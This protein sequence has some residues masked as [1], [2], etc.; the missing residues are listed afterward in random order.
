MVSFLANANSTVQRASEDHLR[1]R[2]MSVYSMLFL[3]MTPLGSFII[4]SISEKT[5]T[6]MALMASSGLCLLASVLFITR[7]KKLI[8]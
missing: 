3:G 8:Q 6:A 7:S 5:S 2:V 4:G 1:G